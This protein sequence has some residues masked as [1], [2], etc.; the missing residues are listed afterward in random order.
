MTMSETFK[1]V[2]GNRYMR[3]NGTVAVIKKDFGTACETHTGER[4]LCQDGHTYNERGMYYKTVKHPLDLVQQVDQACESNSVCF[5]IDIRGGKRA[6]LWVT[7]ENMI[8]SMLDV[9]EKGGGLTRVHKRGPDP[10]RPDHMA[11]SGDYGSSGVYELTFATIGEICHGFV[12]A[13]KEF[14]IVL[15]FSEGE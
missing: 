15:T 11:G 12:K 3:R 7:V 4:Y 2:V 8:R 1:V 6:P 14:H 10:D 13:K 9:P 5:Q